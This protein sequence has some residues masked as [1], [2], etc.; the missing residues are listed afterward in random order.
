MLRVV[1]LLC[2][3]IMNEIERNNIQIY[4]FPDSEDIDE[5]VALKKLK[6]ICEQVSY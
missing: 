2:V 3:Q 4:E 5:S 6:V 1:A